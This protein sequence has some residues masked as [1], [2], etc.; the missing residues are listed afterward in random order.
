[1]SSEVRVVGNLGVGFG[2][3]WVAWGKFGFWWGVLYG[4]CWPIWLGY[5]LA[6]YLLK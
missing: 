1:M 3:F 2:I 6:E 5:R 4:A